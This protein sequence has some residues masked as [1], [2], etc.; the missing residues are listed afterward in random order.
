[1]AVLGRLSHSLALYAG[2]EALHLGATVHLLDRLRPDRQR[3]ALAF[4]GTVI[5]AEGGPLSE[6][7]VADLP[8][9]L[10]DL[11]G[12]GDGPLAGTATTRPAMA[13]RP[14]PGRP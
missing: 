5:T 10:A 3:R 11:A 14:T 1:M 12:A 8:D 9:D 4:Q 13:R 6:V 2:A 7:F